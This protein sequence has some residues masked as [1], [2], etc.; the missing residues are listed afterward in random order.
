MYIRRKVFSRIWDEETSEEKLFS[1]KEINL[2]EVT[3][4]RKD[5]EGL[6]EEGKKVLKE[7]RDAYAK[8]LRKNYRDTMA[9]IDKVGGNY[10]KLGTEGSIKGGG[11]KTSYKVTNFKAVGDT[12]EDFVNT[13]KNAIRS[14]LG[15]QSKNAGEIM[16]GE[17][18]AR[19]RE[20]PKAEPIAQEV[21]NSI[22]KKAEE[23]AKDQ[24]KK[25]G[26]KLSRNQ[27]IGA[28]AL[29]TAALVSAG[30]YAYK[31]HKKSKEKKD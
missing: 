19:Y 26:F 28:A 11:V 14:E 10:E 30:T 12:A 5:Y 31:K 23:A 3:F 18:L 25:K 9:N 24:V 17:T 7:R 15:K 1:V 4:A 29:G 21:K 8:T 2:E 20:I 13:H 16:R 27:K 22:V 6:T